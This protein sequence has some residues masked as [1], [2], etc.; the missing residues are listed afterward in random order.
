MLSQSGVT[1]KQNDCMGGKQEKSISS[2]K[3]S[4]Q[5]WAEWICNNQT[6]LEEEL[7]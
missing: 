6:E 4:V 3:Q 7:A 1:Q 5:K 2:A